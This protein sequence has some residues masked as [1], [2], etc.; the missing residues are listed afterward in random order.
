MRE[1]LSELVLALELDR[2]D[3]HVRS[4]PEIPT[5]QCRRPCV[6]ECQCPS[7]PLFFHVH[8]NA[9]E[10]VQNG[11]WIT[12]RQLYIL[13]DRVSATVPRGNP[14]FSPR[15]GSLVLFRPQN[16]KNRQGNVEEPQPNVT[17]VEICDPPLWETTSRLSTR[18]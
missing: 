15:L 16:M 1:S 8:F 11:C 7:A 12:Q 17:V 2:W 14:L 18:I 9:A 3:P 5:E 13:G 10:D 6:G 4:R